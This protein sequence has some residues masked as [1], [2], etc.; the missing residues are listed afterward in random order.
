MKRHIPVSKRVSFLF[1]YSFLTILLFL[2][3]LSAERVGKILY[4]GYAEDLNDTT[5]QVPRDIVAL[6]E[7]IYVGH[8]DS[9]MVI[10]D[11]PS[12]FF[13]ID[14]SGSMYNY[15][16]DSATSTLYPPADPLGNRFKVTRDLIDTLSNKRRFPGIEVGVAVFGTCLYYD[17]TDG[18]T[19]TVAGEPGVGPFDDGGYIPL[20]KLDRDYNGKTGAEIIKEKLQTKTIQKTVHINWAGPDTTIEYEWVDLTAPST[21]FFSPGTDINIGFTAEKKAMRA[22]TYDPKNHYGIFFSDGEANDGMNADAYVAGTGVPTAFTIFFTETGQAPQDLIDMNNNIQNN[23]YSS[24]NPLSTLWPFENTTYDTLMNF[25]MEK[26]ISIFEQNTQ[27]IPKDIVINGINDS[28]IWD[29]EKF[30]LPGIIPLTGKITDFNYDISYTIT[31]DSIGVNG[32]TITVEIDTSV[33]TQFSAEVDFNMVDPPDSCEVWYWDRTLKLYYNNNQITIIDDEDMENLQ[34]QFAFNPGDAEYIYTDVEVE[35]SSSRGNQ[36]DKETFTLAK[37]GTAD[38]FSVEF[39]R[40][41]N[42]DNITP[43]DGVLQHYSRDT[44]IAVFRNKEEPQLPLDT[45]RIII[46]IKLNDPV[47]I[48]CAYYHDNNADGYVDSIYV[49]ATTEIE[50]GLTNAHVQEMLDNAITLPAF[51]EFTING[52]G[53][54]S[55]GFHIV[56]SEDRSNNPTTFVKAEDKLKAAEYVFPTGGYVVAI[57][58]PIYDRVAPIIHWERKSAY[59]VDYMVDTVSDTLTVKF[60][61]PV[62]RVTSDEPFYFLDRDNNTN[63]TVKLSDAGQPDPDKM[64]FYVTDLSGVY[65]MEEGDSLWIQETDRVEDTEGNHQNN[66]KNTRRKLYVHRITMPYDFNPVAISPIN[67][68]NIHVHKIPS[69][70]ITVL[71]SQGILD[72]LN[73]HQNANGSYVG[74]LIMALPDPEN[75]GNFMPELEAEGHISI[76]DAVGNRVIQRDRMAW[77]HEE[78]RLLYV[79]N[80]KNENGRT[81]G[82][83]SYLAVIEI[84]DVTPSLTDQNRGKKSAKQILLGVGSM[85]Y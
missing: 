6:S 12:I 83:G 78:K 49:K 39:K 68:A 20:L 74:M 57:T 42:P 41:L 9:L 73:L 62:N 84:E 35:I 79:W 46:P 28:V 50:G 69:E 15:D 8:P 29:G 71:E 64:V 16:Y 44:L 59:L 51:R 67:L 33:T 30:I 36:K 60:S 54:V 77:W 37:Q 14:H 13:I 2:C 61:E 63:Y 80:V 38:L 52:G 85:T 1:I 17:T 31:Y 4:K 48:E 25:L 70:I 53:V 10:V 22:S 40:E 58:A 47:D 75:I 18:I 7:H 45:L 43:G 72:D 55:G 21:F 65:T 11:T 27:I 32:D 56:V 81:V 5:I 76:F 34:M 66:K 26:V 82:T 23:G 24:S 3:T 19:V